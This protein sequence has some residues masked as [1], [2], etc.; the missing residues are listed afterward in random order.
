M[1][2]HNSADGRIDAVMGSD[3]LIEITSLSA[4]DDFVGGLMD[5]DTAICNLDGDSMSSSSGLIQRDNS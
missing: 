4:L 1:N 2:N 3:G 5:P